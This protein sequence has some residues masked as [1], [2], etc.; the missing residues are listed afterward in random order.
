MAYKDKSK[1]RAAELRWY[2]RNRESVQ[3]GKR[4]RWILTKKLL[5]ELKNRPCADCGNSYP[6]YVMDYD[7]LDAKTKFKMVSKL[8]NYS[9][10]KI[11]EEVAKC[12]L[13]CANCHRIRTHNREIAPVAQLDEQVDSNDQ[14]AGSSPV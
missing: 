5:I 9:F 11:K 12:E 13:V 1:Q 3:Q 14:G 10:G 4:E 7:H 8:I 2:Y 6:D